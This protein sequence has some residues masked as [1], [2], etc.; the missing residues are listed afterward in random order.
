M[1]TSRHGHAAAAGLLAPVARIA[2]AWSAW[3]ARPGHARP[4]PLVEELEARLLYSADPAGVGLALAG[5]VT[6]AAELTKGAPVD[7]DD[8]AIIDYNIRSLR[9]GWLPAYPTLRQKKT[10]WG[11]VKT[12]IYYKGVDSYTK[13]WSDQHTYGGKLTENIV[14]ALA[15]DI[16]AES[17][18]RV[19]HK[20]PVVMTVHDEIQSETRAGFGD[21]EEFKRLMATRPAWAQDFPLVV[22]GWRGARYRK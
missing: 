17:M 10:P 18:V 8:G 22:S 3:R 6:V 9:M 2:R 7:V 21:H 13:K 15:R 19:D 12:T 16:L 14:Q 20:Y 11:K 5:A 1:K 4:A